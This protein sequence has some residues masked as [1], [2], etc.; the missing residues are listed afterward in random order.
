MA[1]CGLLYY[2]AV[3]GHRLTGKGETRKGP[4]MELQEFIKETLVQIVDG[5]E[6][7]QSVVGEK[8]VTI[9]RSGHPKGNQL[10]GFDVAV[11]VK[12]DKS[13]EGKA[14]VSVFSISWVS[15]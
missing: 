9:S 2:R 10:V 8:G 15:S 13:T 3:L 14:G 4:A 6:G 12:E 1:A 11:L 7:A 5:V